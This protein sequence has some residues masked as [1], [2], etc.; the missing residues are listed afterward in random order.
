MTIRG[1]VSFLIAC[2]CVAAAPAGAAV[3]RTFVASYGLDTNACSVAAPCR[4][5]TQAMRQTSDGGEIIVLHSAGYGPVVIE[6]SASIIAPPGIYAGIAVTSGVGIQI[7]GT[8]IDVSLRGLSLNGLGGDFG[9]YVQRARRVQLERVDVSGFPCGIGGLSGGDLRLVDAHVWGSGSAG[10]TLAPALPDVLYA[11]LE[12]V[13]IDGNFIGV[14]AY[15]D[16]MV[17]VRNSSFARNSATGFSLWPDA[18]ETVSVA[19]EHC[20][21]ASNGVAGINVW[22]AGLHYVS[23]ADSLFF[24]HTG[25][26]HGALYIQAGS[27]GAVYTLGN[28]T[29]LGNA[30]NV[31]GG[32]AV[33]T[34]AP[35]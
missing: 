21:F 9:I 3:Q 24:G 4:T 34:L 14:N 26:N 12:R 23:I 22:G 19:F 33:V 35:F 6:K 17:T 32:G 28:N 1:V 25:T 27:P 10:I 16:T 29:M 8:G 11:T 31:V 5:F 30:A 7:N 2:L 13:R 15:N 20:S 18:G